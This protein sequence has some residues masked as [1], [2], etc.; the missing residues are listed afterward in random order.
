M[1][2]TVASMDDQDI[3][4]RPRQVILHLN[5]QD[6]EDFQLELTP[7]KAREI[8]WRLEEAR[9]EVSTSATATLGLIDD[10]LGNA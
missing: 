10:A 3:K 5:R 2:E 9:T 8:A 6:G 4:V 1:P 7:G